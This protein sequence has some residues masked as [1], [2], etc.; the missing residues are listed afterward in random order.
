MAGEGVKLTTG[1]AAREAE[2]SEALIRKAAQDGRL[3]SEK[4]IG[5]LRLFSL[6]AVREFAQ[7]IK[8][9]RAR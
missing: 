5:G 1:P 3:A 9:R 8:G 4:T 6:E 2:C 7:Q